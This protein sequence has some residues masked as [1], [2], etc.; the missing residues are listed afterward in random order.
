M[1]RWVRRGG[2]FMV[3]YVRNLLRITV[4]N[5]CEGICLD[6]YLTKKIH[7]HT[8]LSEFIFINIINIYY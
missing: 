8:E 4:M 3:A 2:M 1:M 7:T 6:I 5:E